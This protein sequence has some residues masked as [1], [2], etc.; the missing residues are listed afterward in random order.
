MEYLSPLLNRCLAFVNPPPP[1]DLGLTPRFSNDA[2]KAW[3]NLFAWNGKP[4]SHTLPAIRNGKNVEISIAGTTMLPVFLVTCLDEKQMNNALGGYVSTGCRKT[5]DP[6]ELMEI[7]TFLSPDTAEFLAPLRV[8]YKHL[9]DPVQG[10]E[11]GSSEDPWVELAK[12]Q[13]EESHP[14]S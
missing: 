5:S 4:L 6:D 8:P 9:K 7:V 13:V 3:Y 14:T 2:I 12:K 1:T 11:E 10:K